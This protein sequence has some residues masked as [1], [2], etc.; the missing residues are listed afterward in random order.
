MMTST[1]QRPSIPSVRSRYEWWQNDSFHSIRFGLSVVA[2]VDGFRFAIGGGG[3]ERFTQHQIAHKSAVYQFRT[4]WFRGQFLTTTIKDYRP[5]LISHAFGWKGRHHCH[6]ERPG[7]SIRT[8]IEVFDSEG[9][10]QLQL[11]KILDPELCPMLFY[12]N[13]VIVV[14]PKDPLY[15]AFERCHIRQTIWSTEH[16]R[17][18][19]WDERPRCNTTDSE[20]PRTGVC[21]GETKPTIR[22]TYSIARR[23]PTTHPSATALLERLWFPRMFI[24]HLIQVVRTITSSRWLQLDPF[25]ARSPYY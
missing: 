15:Q 24:G 4:I 12:A 1:I 7:V 16:L 19:T 5:R 13:G 23:K 6:S 18:T 2:V 14:N 8:N 17:S 10:F 25:A 3:E 22:P 9:N 20:V 21:E 11:W